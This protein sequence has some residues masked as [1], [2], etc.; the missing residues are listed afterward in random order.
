[1]IPHNQAFGKG[2]YK[3]R[4]VLSAFIVLMNAFDAWATLVLI[5]RGAAEANP[6]MR[7][8]M[9]HGLDHFWAWKIFVVTA[10]LIGLAAAADKFSL[11][12]AGLILAAGVF[13]ALTALHAY[14]L[15]TVPAMPG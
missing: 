9:S 15:L 7:W 5:R 12:R 10:L 13:T 4:W 3:W 8:V 14:L 6:V 1:M 2:A 11:A